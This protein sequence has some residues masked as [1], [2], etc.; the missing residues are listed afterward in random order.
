MIAEHLPGFVCMIR[1][2]DHGDRLEL[3]DGA[4]YLNVARLHIAQQVFIEIGAM[5]PRHPGLQV[6]FKL[7]RTPHG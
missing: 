4:G 5:W 1:V 6:R 7:C 2:G 3:C